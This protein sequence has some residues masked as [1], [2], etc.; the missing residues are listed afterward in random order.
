MVDEQSTQDVSEGSEETSSGDDGTEQE[1]NSESDETETASESTETSSSN[2]VETDTHDTTIESDPV[3]EPTPTEHSK[4]PASASPETESSFLPMALGGVAA[5]AIGFAAAFFGLAQKPDTE[6]AAL[7]QQIQQI[8]ASVGEQSEAMS[9][10]TQQV[11][12][13]GAPDMSAVESRV[14]DV[15]ASVADLLTRL[16]STEATLNGVDTRL[17]TLEKRPVTEGA[18]QEAV[19]AYERE[20]EAAAADIARQRQ[21]LEALISNAIDTEDAAEE[22]SKAAIRRAGISR[23]LSALESG[24]PFEG[25]LADL[26]DAGA[27]VPEA[28]NAVAATGVTPV[29][30]LQQSFPDA[31]RAALAIARSTDGTADGSGGFTSFLRTQLG[32]RS[33]EPREGNDP[34]AILSRAEAATR[35]GR[36]SD[37]L[38]EIDTLPDDAKAEFS[39][40]SEQATE[41]LNALRAAQDLSE[42]LK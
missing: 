18:S 39:A 32:A 5:G 4:N 12:D 10:L 35:E 40:W 6:A 19:A 2:E 13:L 21:E 11:D 38:S 23:L 42:T 14:G 28:L 1:N 9:S 8:E 16:E 26:Q 17:T 7:S 30:D 34:D 41:R 29:T 15:Q 27:E 22:A 24:A 36:L 20:L 25:A 37:A 3:E 31:A 33:L